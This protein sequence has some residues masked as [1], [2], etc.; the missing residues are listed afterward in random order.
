MRKFSAPVC[1]LG[2]G[3]GRLFKDRDIVNPES[4]VLNRLQDISHSQNLNSSNDYLSASPTTAGERLSNGSER[5]SSPEDDNVVAILPAVPS[6]QINEDMTSKATLSFPYTLNLPDMSRH[7]QDNTNETNSERPFQ[8]R[9]AP[10]TRLNVSSLTCTLS[11]SPSQDRDERS[12]SSRASNITAGSN[13]ASPQDAALDNAALNTGNPIYI[14]TTEAENYVQASTHTQHP[15]ENWATTSRDV[16]NLKALSQFPWFHG[17]ISRNNASQLVLAA[18]DAGTG[19]YLVRQSESR[20]GD[21]VLTFNYHNKAK[22]RVGVVTFTL[23][24][25]A[26]AR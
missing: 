25:R 7:D 20:E 3:I 11:T 16:Q 22:V 6:H 14:E 13:E 9:L 1:I 12:N 5:I 19:Q 18:G 17:M 2:D 24:L 21:F 26:F 23:Y 8:E 15:Y 10:Y 4:T